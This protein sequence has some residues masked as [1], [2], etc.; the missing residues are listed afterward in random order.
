MTSSTAS[1]HAEETGLP[2]YAEPTI[3][4]F[5]PYAVPV[6]VSAA[7]FSFDFNIDQLNEQ[8][9]RYLVSF[10]NTSNDKIITQIQFD[11]DGE[12]KV[13]ANSQAGGGDST[14]IYGNTNVTW[15]PNTWVNLRIEINGTGL[16]VFVDDVSKYSGFVATPNIDI[17]QVSIVHDNRISTA[18]FDNFKTNNEALSTDDFVVNNTSFRYLGATKNLLFQSSILQL[19][20]L[21]VYN[22]T[23]QEVISTKLQGN[24]DR[25]NVESLPSG[26]YIAQVVSEGRISSFKFS[27]Y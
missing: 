21:R 15:S 4:A 14:V 7:V 5:Y 11:F 16:E 10:S 27:K 24:E 25:V 19:D 12:I 22:M 1:P 13:L 8:T 20:E 23:G 6:D 3:G 18:F 9:S 26:I 2:V 17:N